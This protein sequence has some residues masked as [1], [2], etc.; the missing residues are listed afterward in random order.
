MNIPS[1]HPT[2]TLVHPHTGSI[3]D[4]VFQYVPM[5]DVPFYNC[6]VYID[7]DWQKQASLHE[8]SLDEARKWWNT[9]VKKGYNRK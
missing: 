9:L 3:I 2:L 7:E 6:D 5:T 4:A 1:I 8:M